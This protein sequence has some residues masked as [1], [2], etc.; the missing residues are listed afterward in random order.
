MHL[1]Y[2]PHCLYSAVSFLVLQTLVIVCD[3]PIYIYIPHFSAVSPLFEG[4][5]LSYCLMFEGAS[6][7]LL[8]NSSC[9]TLSP[10][11]DVLVIVPLCDMTPA[12]H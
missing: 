10:F 6:I 5:S 7:F 12:V 11:D 1:F 4:T 9:E 2:S 8:F 3:M